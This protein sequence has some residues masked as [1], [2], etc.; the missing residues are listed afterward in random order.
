MRFVSIGSRAPITIGDIRLNKDNVDEY[1]EIFERRLSLYEKAI[2]QRVYK[3]LSG[4]YNGEATESCAR[5]NSVFAA[6]IQQHDVVLCIETGPIGLNR[7]CILYVF[8]A[9]SEK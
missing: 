3:T 9:F 6:L 5:S 8:H 7:C 4:L 1:Q 2:R